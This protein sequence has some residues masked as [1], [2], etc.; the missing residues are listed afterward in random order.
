MTRENILVGT[1]YL[2]DFLT[3]HVHVHAYIAFLFS[4]FGS[5][6]FC[7]TLYN[8]IDHYIYNDT[9]NNIFSSATTDSKWFEW[10]EEQ[11]NVSSSQ[12]RKITFEQFK[13]TLH[14]EKVTIF[15]VYNQ[16]N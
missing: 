9:Y 11:F 4:I 15:L 10:I 1:V 8:D 12:G 7:S 16:S 2:L 5:Y 14:L 3:L 13:E 6:I